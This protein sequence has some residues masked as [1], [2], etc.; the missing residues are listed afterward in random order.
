MH[1]RERSHASRGQ[2]GRVAR[3]RRALWTQRRQV[4]RRI[5]LATKEHARRSVKD[6][7]VAR[8][9]CTWPKLDCD[10]PSLLRLEI[11]EIIH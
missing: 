10:Y 4:R 7:L 5:M 3:G 6:E 9:R 2:F 8:D 11:L 1:T